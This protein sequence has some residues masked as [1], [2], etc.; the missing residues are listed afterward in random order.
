MK[1]VPAARGVTLFDT[2]DP[3]AMFP[4]KV[5]DGIYSNTPGAV[6]YRESWII[7]CNTT[8]IVEFVFGY[9]HLQL[10]LIWYQFLEER[11]LGVSLFSLWCF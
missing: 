3:H 2:G 4:A 9:T 1:N 5:W 7:P 11:L 6:R 8:T 10:R